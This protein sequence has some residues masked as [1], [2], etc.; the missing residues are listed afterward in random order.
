MNLFRSFL[1]SYTKDMAEGVSKSIL[2]ENLNVLDL[3]NFKTQTE[4]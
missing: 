4:R 1:L 2:F 3:Q